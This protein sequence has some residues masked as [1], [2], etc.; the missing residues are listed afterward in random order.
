MLKHLLP[1]SPRLRRA[2]TYAGEFV[3]IVA[4][5]VGVRAYMTRSVAT[6]PAP[7]IEAT[8]LGGEAISLAALGDRPVLVYFWATWCPICSGMRGS[9]ADIARDHPVVAVAMQSGSNAE[10]LAYLSEHQWRVPVVVNDIDGRLAHAYGVR[11]V[12]ASF[13]VDRRGKIRAV[14]IGYTTEIG[15]RLRLWWAGRD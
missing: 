14:E 2:L 3:L 11:G 7:A 1:R 6:G 13:I 10:V 4:L 9:I 8:T 12:P 15:L 5:I